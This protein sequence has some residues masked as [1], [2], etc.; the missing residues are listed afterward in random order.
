MTISIDFKSNIKKASLVLVREAFF[1][2]ET[3]VKDTPGT[4]KKDEEK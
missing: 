3:L 1:D 2:S 4:K